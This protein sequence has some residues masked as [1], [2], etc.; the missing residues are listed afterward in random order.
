MKLFI[1]LAMMGIGTLCKGDYTYEAGYR[2]GYA[3]AQARVED[4]PGRY[5]NAPELYADAPADNRA[6]V[7]HDVYGFSNPSRTCYKSWKDCSGC[8]GYLSSCC[9]SKN[10][11]GGRQCKA[12][13][14]LY[15]CV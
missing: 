1:V 15:S 12:G 8:R 13:R 14:S 11:S 4:A 2:A 5:V 9:S 6:P 10:C 3:D 7:E